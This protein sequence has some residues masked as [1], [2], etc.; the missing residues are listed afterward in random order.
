MV[1]PDLQPR[2][3]ACAGSDAESRFLRLSRSW[4]SRPLQEALDA[5]AAVGPSLLVMSRYLV[6]TRC[7]CQAV[8]TAVLDEK[9]QPISASAARFGV[10]ENA[11]AHSIHPELDRFDVA[12]LCSFCGR[13]T[14]RSFYAD[15]LRRAPEPPAAEPTT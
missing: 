3:R 6:S 9:R 4:V 14:L 15:A 7:E 12:W 5:G 13:N 1:T 10:R 11:P 8:L 2:H